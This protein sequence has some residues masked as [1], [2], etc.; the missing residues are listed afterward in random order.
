[1]PAAKVGREIRDV[2]VMKQYISTEHE[3]DL[4]GRAS[5]APNTYNVAAGPGMGSQIVRPH[6]PLSILW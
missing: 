3:K 4:Y 5:P 1:M 6:S 2:A